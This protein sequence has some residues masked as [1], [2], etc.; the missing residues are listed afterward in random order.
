M[1]CD[2]LTSSLLWSHIP[3]HVRYSTHKTLINNHDKAPRY[4]L[5][6]L[7]MAASWFL[8]CFLLAGSALWTPSDILKIGLSIHKLTCSC[9]R[10]PQFQCRQR[11][12]S[13]HFGRCQPSGNANWIPNLLVLLHN[14]GHLNFGCGWKSIT[15]SYISWGQSMCGAYLLRSLR[16]S[17]GVTGSSPTASAF[18]LSERFLNATGTLGFGP[19]SWAARI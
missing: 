2:Q 4:L 8:F 11:G 9:P 13:W 7:A 14:S 17:M 16:L 15:S 18:W 6:P 3:V 19:A 10:Q 12:Q 1:G 5:A